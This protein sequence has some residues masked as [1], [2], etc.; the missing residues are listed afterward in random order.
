MQLSI[1]I[2]Q[3]CLE[4]V[5]CSVAVISFF[6]SNYSKLKEDNY[7]ALQYTV[8]VSSN[9]LLKNWIQPAAARFAGFFLLHVRSVVYACCRDRIAIKTLSPNLLALH[10]VRTA[11][12]A[13]RCQN[14]P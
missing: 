7:G 10:S 1:S 12:A 3:N 4:V 9:F 5:F 14:I 8:S 11:V 6:Y 2:D 13:S